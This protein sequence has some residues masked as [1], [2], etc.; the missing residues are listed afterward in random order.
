MSNLE[1]LGFLNFRQEIEGKI[2]L[3]LKQNNQGEW[4]A[5]DMGAGGNMLFFIDNWEQ[6]IKTVKNELSNEDL[7]DHVLITKRLSIAPDDWTYEIV[8]PVEYHGVFNQM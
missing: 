3:A 8:F 1:A 4:F 5:G 6:A 7:L 2:D